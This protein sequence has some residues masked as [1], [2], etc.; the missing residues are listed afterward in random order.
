MSPGTVSTKGSERNAFFAAAFFLAPPSSSPS[1][2][3]SPPSSSTPGLLLRRARVAADLEQLA[4]P[5]D[6]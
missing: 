4:R 3:S 1:P 2:S 6:R 5:L